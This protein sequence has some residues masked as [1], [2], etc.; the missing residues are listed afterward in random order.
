MLNE[1]YFH[2]IGIAVRNIEQTATL[3][4][5]AG[6][7]MTEPVIDT[8]RHV[9]ICFLKKTGTVFEKEKMPLI[10][11]VE[12]INELAPVNKILEKSGVSPY[13]FCYETEDLYGS[14]EKLKKQKYLLIQ[15]PDLAIALE[16]RKVCFMFHKDA[17][18]IELL[19]K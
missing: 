3:Y 8:L 10:E 12:P 5:T 7:A 2:H 17:G 15:K 18:L 9:R 13:H 14:V 19:E 16:N 4:L 11:L 1:L 6:F